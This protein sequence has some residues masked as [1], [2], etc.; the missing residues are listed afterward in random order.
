MATPFHLSVVT[1]SGKKFSGDVTAIMLPGMNGYFGILAHH[2]PLI[3]ALAQGYGKATGLE[4][5]EH[6]F[7]IG[8]GYVE[9]SRNE[10]IVMAGNG[11]LV[12]SRETALELLKNPHPWDAAEAL[13]ESL[14]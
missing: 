7:I 11:H 5:K 6:H 2:A 8:N 13:A 14:S 9:V 12:P 3:A 1:A 10:V 4:G